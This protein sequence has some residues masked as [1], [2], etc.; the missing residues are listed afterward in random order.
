MFFAVV[1]CGGVFFFGRLTR[2]ESTAGS[3]GAFRGMVIMGAATGLFVLWVVLHTAVVSI[4]QVQAGYVGVVYQFGSIIGQK[5]EGLQFIAPWQ[6]MEKASVQVQRHSF[7]KIDGFS[8]ETQDV[9]VTATLNYSISPNAVQNLYRTVGANWFDRLIETRINNY[10]KEET[11][12][13]EA[14]AVAPNRE[15]IRNAVKDRLSKDLAPYSITINDLLIDNIDFL[16]EFKQ[17]IENKQIATQ[18][19]LRETERVKQKQAE[20]QQAI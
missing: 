7:Q 5:D 20:A 18:D 11:V 1:V 2:R 3:P 9:F 14:T 19:A 10:F 13:Y 8:K 17:A 12:K 16:P 6:T 15:V 4:Q